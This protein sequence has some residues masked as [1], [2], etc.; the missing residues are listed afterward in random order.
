MDKHSAEARTSSSTADHGQE[1]LL[2]RAENWSSAHVTFERPRDIGSHCPRCGGLLTR[3]LG[4]GVLCACCGRLWVIR[5]WLG[6][7]RIPL[8]ETSQ[9]G[10]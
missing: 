2:R 6:G 7:D 10:V 9:S 3:R 1:R 8:A 5:E 4:P